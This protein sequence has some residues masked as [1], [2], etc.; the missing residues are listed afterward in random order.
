MR[1]QNLTAACRSRSAQPTPHVHPMQALFHLVHSMFCVCMLFAGY[2]S[3]AALAATGI[4]KLPQLLREHAA[5]VG[6]QTVLLLSLWHALAN[7]R[8]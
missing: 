4:S 3:H 7:F 5:K 2:K 8:C 6:I 1:W